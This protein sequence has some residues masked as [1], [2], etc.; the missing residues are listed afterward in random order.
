MSSPS[1]SQKMAPRASTH[2]PVRFRRKTHLN[3]VENQG[4]AAK[5]SPEE[6]VISDWLNGTSSHQ[7]RIASAPLMGSE[8]GVSM[9]TAVGANTVA[10][11]STFA[12]AH[13]FPKV[14]ISDR[15]SARVSG[16]CSGAAAWGSS[17]VDMLSNIHL[18]GTLRA[19]LIATLAPVAARAQATC[20][21]GLADT[22]RAGWAAY[23]T[24]ALDTAAVRFRN[25]DRLCPNALDARVGLGFVALRQDRA[26]EA[27]SLFRVVLSLDSGYADA[28]DGRARSA[29]RLGDRPAAFA[30][31]RRA[32]ALDP[33]NAD[34][35]TWL[36]QVAPDRNRP[37]LAPRRRPSR[38]QL[39]SRTRGDRFEIRAGKRWMPFY[40][41]G[42]NL[43][44]ALPGRF[45]AEFPADSA[46]Y[47][48]WLD[49]IS[50]MHANTVRVYTILPPAFYR[51]LRGWNR[52]NPGRVFWLV[53]GVWTELPPG[54][55]FDDR[56]WKEG[57]RQE[58]RRVADLLHGAVELPGR[59]GHA[60][61]RY[62]A[63]VSS[64]TLGYIIGREWEPYAVKAYDDRV[65][66]T[67]YRGR[68]L[69]MPGGSAIDAWMAE[70]CDY[71]LAYE[72]DRYNS[73]RPIAY[74]NWPTLD[75]LNH[76]TESTAK[77]ER[78]WRREPEESTA[79]TS[80]SHEE[81]AVALDAALIRP[82]AANPAG[83]FASYHVYPYYPD[84]MNYDP[85]YLA[86]RSSEGPSTYF[87]YLR[88]LKRHHP[89][90]PLLVAE[91]GVPSSRG[92]AH[93][94]PQGWNHGG[95]DETAMA[96]IDA[97]LTRDIRE[98]GAAGGIVFAWMDE[99]FKRNW[100]VAGY[101]IPGDHTPRWHNA[102]DAE[103]HYGILAQRAGSPDRRPSLGG[104]PGR[105]LTL[106]ELQPADSGM[107]PLR[108]GQDEA[109]VYLAMPLSGNFAWDSL[110]VQVALDTY[111][112]E[113]GQ[114]RLADGAL[115]SDIGME[116][117]ALF[118]RPDDAELRVTPDY[119]PYAPASWILRGD[120]FGRLYR[121]PAGSLARDD[122]VFDSLFVI[123]NRAR[124]GRDGTFFPSEGY[125]RGRLRFG[126]ETESTLSDWF[127]DTVAGLLELRL[128]WGLLNVTDPST[129][130]VLAERDGAPFATATT[131][132]F[133]VGVLV[134]RT[135]DGAVA[136]ALPGRA[137]DGRWP[138]Q[139]F[140]TWR[141]DPWTEP[142][143]YPMLKPVYDSLRATWRR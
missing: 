11:R 110:E 83:W 4:P 68:Y 50:A 118:R 70:Q 33:R 45:P 27:D 8:N 88:D 80:P 65:A 18:C 134:R 114:R 38:L 20:A 17:S 37:A 43:G 15:P 49:T 71:L 99:W 56:A 52:T 35:G 120:D 133:H 28:W 121:H 113:L 79:T 117:V 91:Y 58:M 123:T 25:A 84:F 22:I 77:E 24:G 31:G 60:G 42:V 67:P 116:F 14:S 5:I 78:R 72:A 105:W 54:D 106:P 2:S 141:W 128:P 19:V 122:G 34:L 98:S 130:T 39:V 59:P 62:D 81:D 112:P 96:A 109:Y 16:A 139:A 89:G 93:L 142:R 95:H 47:A 74:T 137:A 131:D 41:R 23:R 1:V 97:R 26:V 115:E 69:T 76:A 6:K 73:L 125:N 132:G 136:Q 119:N 126:R 48:G 21:P 30:A 101:E 138:A 3:S 124:Y 103:Q 127:H 12:L 55:D 61:G 92:I 32:L 86:A 29:W 9:K 36:D 82:T 90:I 53:H 102:M 104:D 57:F 85:G 107:G 100:L 108:V 87:G 13:P 129:G 111:A 44:V 75:P 46:L 66:A 40:V 51:A 63:D 7:R 10:R 135:R 94:Q 140:R 143:S 64:W